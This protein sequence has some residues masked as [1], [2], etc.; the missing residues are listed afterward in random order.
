MTA[1]NLEGIDEDFVLKELSFFWMV[2]A[3]LL[4]PISHECSIVEKLEC[5]EN[6]DIVS[7]ESPFLY[8]IYFCNI[9][10]LPLSFRGDAM[11]FEFP[12]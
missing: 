11:V 9:D 5:L 2:S 3:V 12:K 7:T 1:R 4:N 6:Y 10:I 8:K